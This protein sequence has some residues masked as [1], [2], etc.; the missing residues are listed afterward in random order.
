ME[1]AQDSPSAKMANSHL[2]EGDV[3][4]PDEMNP[5]ASG[6][7]VP[8]TDA[9]VEKQ[10]EAGVEM[11]SEAEGDISSAAT[12]KRHK[13]A[14]EKHKFNTLGYQ[15][16]QKPMIYD[17]VTVR[18][19]NVR[20]RP[21]LKQV[22][23]NQGLSDR[24][25][26]LGERFLLDTFKST[27]E[28]FP[29]PVLPDNRT[30]VAGVPLEDSW[31]NIVQSHQAMDKSARHQQEVLWELLYT[32]LNY[33]S[34]LTVVTDI[35]MGALTHL[36][37]NGFL[38]EMTHEYLF[39]NLPSVLD[40]HRRFWEE[41][42]LPMLLE[43]RHT[44]GPFKPLM[45]EEG[46]LQFSQRFSSYLHYCRDEENIMEFARRQMESPLFH[47]YIEW[48]ENCPGCGRMR[49]GDM[50]AKPHQRI[51]KYPLLLREVL[52][53]T[54]DPQTQY[55]LRKML[56]SVN[57]FLDSINDHLRLKYEEFA[58]SQSAARLEGYDVPEGVSEEIEK[59]VREICRFD[60]TSPMRGAGTKDIRKLLLEET[61]RIKTRR[62]SKPMVVLLFSDVLL[63]TKAQK[64]SEKLKVVCPPLALD[65]IV[66]APLKDD[67]SFVLV[68]LG[69]LFCAVNIYAVM[70]PST[71]S[72]SEWLKSILA[73]QE[74]LA[75]MRERET[76]QR[77]G[78]FL[79]TDIRM[80]TQVNPNLAEHSDTVREGQD[81][82]LNLTGIEHTLLS[83]QEGRGHGQPQN[84]VLPFPETEEG[85]IFQR[86][87]QA[88]GLQLIGSQPSHISVHGSVTNKIIDSKHSMRNMGL[89]EEEGDENRDCNQ[90]ESSET[91]LIGSREKRVVGGY[92]ESSNS[93]FSHGD[94][95]EIH[96]N[97]N[98]LTLFDVGSDVDMSSTQSE[99][100]EMHVK[101][102]DFESEDPYKA[103]GMDS[104]SSEPE[105]MPTGTMKFSRKLNSPRLRK[106]RALG[107]PHTF[108]PQT[109]KNRYLHHDT[110]VLASSANSSDSDCNQKLRNGRRPNP[111]VVISLASVKKNQGMWNTVA[112]GEPAKAQTFLTAELPCKRT[113]LDSQNQPRLRRG[114]VPDMDLQEGQTL[115][116][117]LSLSESSFPLFSQAKIYGTS[118]ENLL[119]RARERERGKERRLE[120]SEKV[121]DISPSPSRSISPSISF[122]E[123]ER[124]REDNQ[125][126][127][128]DQE[129][130]GLHKWQDVNKEL[131][132]KQ[133]YNNEYNC[134]FSDQGASVDWMGWCVDDDEVMVRLHPEG[135]GSR[136]GIA[137]LATIDS[138]G[139]K[140][141]EEQEFGEV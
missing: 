66:C 115:G 109:D 63:L 100:K 2:R 79:L 126:I 107:S 95:S 48:V 35:V 36:H 134:S 124:E 82:E 87:Q 62:E 45:L 17:F 23:F 37:R 41:V 29:L 112:P 60:L 76:S 114:S 44:R 25:P 54:Q 125:E 14:A 130:E 93:S 140:E 101:N 70:A 72:R 27:L 13:G 103:S 22:L 26:T 83:D 128:G 102:D 31:T 19:P 71:E 40:A 141:Q 86:Q 89:T 129:N 28:S 84:G 33:I 49:L 12:Q 74:S 127:L 3:E 131:E 67:V 30:D 18:K 116:L 90:V 1:P 94:S 47:A 32:E 97:V 96:S 34:K 117:R 81:K 51:T 122:S 110:D 50:Q 135:E 120:K 104:R 92:S 61:L 15:K 64:K 133:K 88:W 123:E 138:R 78:G 108:S 136:P 113:G 85:S 139:T 39:S 111:Q 58:L 91:I 55:A 137:V 43:A 11:D 24:A 98:T 106:R 119:A 38:Q 8:V 16:M 52:K 53:C 46:F 21:A 118:P 73:A 68:E 80:E 4:G 6:P 75:T 56:S 10:S 57:G 65:R 99:S 59:F 77:F 121:W 42:M 69:E 105:H 7:R 132:D 20:H 9:E 5:S